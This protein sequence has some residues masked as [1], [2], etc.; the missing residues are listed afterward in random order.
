VP[1]VEAVQVAARTAVTPKHTVALLR[2]P[3][4]F[5]LV[6]LSSEGVQTICEIDDPEEVADLIAR[7]EA[8]SAKASAFAGLLHR[9]A[10][11][12]EPQDGEA[13]RDSGPGRAQRWRGRGFRFDVRGTQ[14]SGSQAAYLA[15]AALGAGF[16]HSVRRCNVRT[17]QREMTTR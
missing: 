5:V 17:Q 15:V 8:P 14:R 3:R 1:Q 16:L 2:L 4:R 12:Y 11:E 6:G 13:E 9:A 10:G 7:V